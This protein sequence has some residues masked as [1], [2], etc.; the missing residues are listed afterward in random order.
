MQRCNKTSLY[1]IY[2]TNLSEMVQLFL[3]NRFM[4]FEV[5]LSAVFVMLW[6]FYRNVTSPAAGFETQFFPN[7]LIA[8]GIVGI[9]FSSIV[10]HEFSHAIVM[11][12]FGIKVKKIKLMFFGGYTEAMEGY[13]DHDTWSPFKDFCVSFV[14]PL[15]NFGIALILYSVFFDKSLYKIFNIVTGAGTFG[16]QINALNYLVIYAVFFNLVIGAF[17]LMPVLPLDGGHVLRAI[18]RGCFKRRWIADLIP[19]LL[20]LVAGLAGIY[21]MSDNLSLTTMRDQG[22]F[23]VVDFLLNLGI[24]GL[25]CLAMIVMGIVSLRKSISIYN[26]GT[27]QDG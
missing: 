13:G 20:S 26:N 15:S 14:G 9:F 8:L 4:K 16:M 22:I 10:V 12:L 25:V 19:G 27:V 7:L 18:L 23:G 3:Y 24:L 6:I 1:T 21:L 2:A 17:N 5:G 11:T